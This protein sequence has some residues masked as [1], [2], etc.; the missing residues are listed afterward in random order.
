LIVFRAEYVSLLRL[1]GVLS[2]QSAGGVTGKRWWSFFLP[3]VKNP[4]ECGLDPEP[5]K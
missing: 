2:D 5:V 4:V 1:G 3:I